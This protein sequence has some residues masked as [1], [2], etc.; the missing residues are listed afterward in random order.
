M[1]PKV[2]WV[3]DLGSPTTPGVHEYRGIPLTVRGDDIIRA[4]AE[5]SK[6]LSDVVF[7][8]ML[9]NPKKGDEH[10]ILGSIA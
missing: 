9:L 5:I 7:N 6:G 4:K 10:Y 2:S 3:R 1:E 8:L